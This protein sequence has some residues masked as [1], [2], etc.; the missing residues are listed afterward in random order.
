MVGSWEWDLESE[1]SVSSPELL[2]ILGRPENSRAPS[3]EEFVAYV[4]PDDR[5]SYDAVVAEA[6]Q[7]HQPFHQTFRIVNESGEV[8][9][10]ESHGRVE[11]G[12]NGEL[13]RMFGAAQDITE[14]EKVEQALR[15]QAKVLEQLPA[16]IIASDTDRL[17]T[18]W[19]SGAE[20]MFGIPAEKAL[21]KRLDD[22]GVVPP[23]SAE[24]REQML[25]TLAEGR[26]WDGEIELAG[27][28]GDPFPALVTNSPTRDQHGEIVGY[29]GVVIDL[30]DQRRFESELML[31]GQLL[32]QV[33]AAVIGLGA[34]RRVTHWNA[35]AEKLSGLRRREVMGRTLPETGLVPDEAATTVEA[36]GRMV[37]GDSWEGEVEMWRKDGTSFPSLTKVSP[38]RD[39]SGKLTGF[40]GVAVDITERKRAEREAQDA[41]L[42]TLKRLSRAVETRDPE[43]GGHIERLGEVAGLLA[44]RVGLP[45]AKVELIRLSAP[46]HDVGKIGIPD[47]ILLKPGKLTDEERAEMRRHAQYGHDILAGS[48]NELLDMAASIALT[49]HERVDGS[50]YP[51]GLR[52]DGIP[53]EGRIVAV[54]DV[55]DALTSDRVYRG[56]MRTEEA[57]AIMREGRGTHFDPDV[58]DVLLSDL[59]AFLALKGRRPPDGPSS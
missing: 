43:T 49:H 6:L 25:E 29:V 27:P 38:A 18:Q 17:I 8:R 35:G 58:L 42:E 54:A 59:D 41:R 45:A 2:R 37:D 47:G 24:A 15:V 3:Y 14:H 4:H 23:R 30:T 55:F 13:K 31:Q 26:T 48:G 53:I 20:S 39:Q 34:D 32:D 5:E 57:I 10:I 36:R 21:G 28:H 12:E 44:E 50:G 16:G 52:G 51:R 56:A 7:D 1:L 33:G 9:T 46:M 19:N 11:V 40:V 22:L